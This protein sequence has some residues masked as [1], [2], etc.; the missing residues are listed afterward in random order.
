MGI[1]AQTFLDKTPHLILGILW[2]L[3]RH[4]QGDEVKQRIRSGPMPAKLQKKLSSSF[5]DDEPNE[6]FNQDDVLLRWVLAVLKHSGCPKK[7]TNLGPDLSDSVG[8]LYLLHQLDPA[9]CPLDALALTDDLA[10]A[11]AMIN[12]SKA[13]GAVPAV[14]AP[15]DILQGNRKVNGL[16]VASIFT[17]YYRQALAEE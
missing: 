2:Q 13:L 5:L 6:A 17:T 7:I 11:D 3:V 14:V 15:A 16:F 12:N 8:L 1:D 4:I 9:K 10:R